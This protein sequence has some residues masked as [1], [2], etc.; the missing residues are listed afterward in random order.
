LKIF[1]QTLLEVILSRPCPENFNRILLKKYSSPPQPLPKIRE[2]IN[3][4]LRKFFSPGPGLKIFP[5]PEYSLLPVPTAHF[6]KSFTIKTA[7]PLQIFSLS[8]GK[9]FCNPA[10]RKKN[11]THPL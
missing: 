7:G 3:R 5:G 1:Q 9:N 6:L 2:P 11:F 10:L 4:T 8:S